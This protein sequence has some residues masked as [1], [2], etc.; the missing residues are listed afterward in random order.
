M[1]SKAT[2]QAE[3]VSAASVFIFDAQADFRLVWQRKFNGATLLFLLNRYV[4]L[5]RLSVIIFVVLLF[6]DQLQL[7]A[8][9]C[10]RFGVQFTLDN[11]SAGC[12]QRVHRSLDYNPDAAS[13]PVLHNEHTYRPEALRT[14][15]A[16]MTRTCVLLGDV[17]VLF[18]TWHSTYRM[19]RDGR[20]AR[21]RA[22]L[23]TLLLRDGTIYFIVI[24]ILSALQLLFLF[25]NDV[26]NIETTFADTLMPL[27]ISRLILNLREFDSAGKSTSLASAG[28][29]KT[30]TVMFASAPCTDPDSDSDSGSF[31]KSD[32]ESSSFAAFVDPLGALVDYEMFWDDLGEDATTPSNGPDSDGAEGC[33]T[34]GTAVSTA[35]AKA[36][37]FAQD[38]CEAE[39]RC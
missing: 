12:R 4:S 6:S 9:P 16:V 5:L 21:F 35:L 29:E 37:L 10:C 1:T 22:S 19:W 39:N 15:I 7:W 27:L 24:L 33:A 34:V 14:V 25:V 31:M 18:I 38:R 30:V 13:A 23:S 8:I 32:F 28:G 17:L 2:Y 26:R 3:L 20:T 11:R 36:Q